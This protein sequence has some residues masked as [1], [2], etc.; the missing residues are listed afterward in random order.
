[1]PDAVEVLFMWCG[2]EI[3]DV[4]VR[5]TAFVYRAGR[6]VGVDAAIEST[7]NSLPTSYDRGHV[8][9]QGGWPQ[10]KKLVPAEPGRHLN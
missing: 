8:G 9:E 7:S 2:G 10:Y 4:R 6:V 3:A 1:M 5:E